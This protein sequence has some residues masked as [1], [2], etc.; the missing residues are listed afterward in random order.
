MSSYDIIRKKA[1]E[2]LIASNDIPTRVEQL[3]FKPSYLGR[4]T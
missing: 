4:L 3:H 2:A 1:N